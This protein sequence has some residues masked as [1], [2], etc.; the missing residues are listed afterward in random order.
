[1]SPVS[2]A[3]VLA[4]LAGPESAPHL[5]S[6]FGIDAPP[7]SPV[8]SGRRFGSL[9]LGE[10]EDYRDRFTATD[11]LAVQCLSV[12][13]PIE[14]SI[15]LLEGDLGREIGRLLCKIPLDAGL[16]TENSRSLIEDGRE[17]DH[18]WQLLKAQDDVGWVTA[19]KLLARKQPHL[20]PVWDNV[21]RCAFGRPR[22]ALI[23]L[24]GLLREDDGAVLG[25]L[26]ELHEETG[27][28][29]H[30]SLLRTL[31]HCRL[32]ETPR[33]PSPKQMPR[34]E[35]VAQWALC[36]RARTSSIHVGAEPL[37]GATPAWSGPRCAALHLRPRRPRHALTRRSAA[38]SIAPEM[39]FGHP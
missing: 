3:Q 17:A 8:F 2:V 30:V 4:L 15:D 6:Y 27:L 35:P 12:T 5:R 39:S 7:G 34:T 29:A 1:M 36:C 26:E 9:E 23:W 13:V 20:I 31:D 25:R 33:L 22:S 38:L 24:D 16:G 11:L 28:P 19:G 32:D 21:V 18:A 10:S 14:V 37:A